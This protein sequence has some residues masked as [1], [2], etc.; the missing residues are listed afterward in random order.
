MYSKVRMHLHFA[1]RASCGSIRVS[2]RS[3]VLTST[4]NVID[5]RAAYSRLIDALPIV[6]LRLVFSHLLSR[7]NQLVNHR[8]VVARPYVLYI[9]LLR[10]L[11]N[12]YRQLHGLS[13]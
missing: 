8:F 13:W 3:D 9:Y 4:T 5:A 6:Q 2:A 10:L 12:F 11:I 7:F 1:G